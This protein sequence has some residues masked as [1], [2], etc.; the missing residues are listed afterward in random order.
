MQLKSRCASPQT[1][2]FLSRTT[3]LRTRRSGSA[4]VATRAPHSTPSGSTWSAFA[5]SRVSSKRATR[6]SG[7][8]TSFT[9][10]SWPPTRP[11]RRQPRRTCEKYGI[12]RASRSTATVWQRRL[13][14]ATRPLRSKIWSSPCAS[15]KKRCWLNSTTRTSG[16]QKLKPRSQCVPANST[17]CARRWRM[18]RRRLLTMTRW[19]TGTCLRTNLHRS[20]QGRSP[21]SPCTLTLRSATTPAMLVP[22]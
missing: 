2:S 16:S 22:A 6:S 18:P 14:K 9:R 8:W 11:P 15:G 4:A 10:A 5:F 21:H 19:K 17:C 12:P 1:S 3:R 20:L 7:S 13:R